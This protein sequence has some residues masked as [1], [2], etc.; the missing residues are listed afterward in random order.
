MRS[1]DAVFT[2]DDIADS[3]PLMREALGWQEQVLPTL[4]SAESKGRDLITFDQ[5][6]AEERDLLYVLNEGDTALY[7]AARLQVRTR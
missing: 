2:L 4:N 1:L 7:A 3:G 6:P 5:L